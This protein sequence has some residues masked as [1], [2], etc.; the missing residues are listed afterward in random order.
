M[1][2]TYIEYELENGGTVLIEAAES[3]EAG[4]VEASR[5]IDIVKKANQRFRQALANVKQSA[6]IFADEM[7]ELEIDEMEV[8]FSITATGELGS[9]AVGK[10]GMGANYQ[11]TLKWKRPEN[12]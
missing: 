3:A 10:I 2:K 12:K 6:Q 1:V 9:F 5:G 4:I 8:A 7:S 11:V